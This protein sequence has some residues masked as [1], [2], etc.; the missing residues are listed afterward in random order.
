VSKKFVEFRNNKAKLYN[1][2][3]K[4]TSAALM[5]ADCELYEWHMAQ[6]NEWEPSSTW[7]WDGVS[8]KYGKVDVKVIDKWWNIP[9]SKGR[10]L[11][12]QACIIDHFYFIEKLSWPDRPLQEG[13]EVEVGFIGV[14]TWEKMAQVIQVSRMQGYGYYVDVRKHAHG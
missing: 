4:P 11:F 3:D 7:S 13:D 8:D 1:K 6:I 10:N 12:R 2:T 14:M 5:R 9:I